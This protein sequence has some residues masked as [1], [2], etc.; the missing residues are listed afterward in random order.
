M[1]AINSNS[2]RT[3]QGPLT[4]WTPELVAN[5]P[6]PFMAYTRYAQQVL[7]I[8]YASTK[9]MVVLRQRVDDVFDR[10]PQATWYSLCRIVNWCKTKRIRKPR[11][12][13]LVDLVPE[14]WAARVLPELDEPVRDENIERRIADALVVETDPSWRRRLIGAM[15][16]SSR[17]RVLNDWMLSRG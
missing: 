7:G 8:P 1:P 13:M 2:H 15:G 10:C 14:A 11:V 16:N 4:V 3:G 9:D 17:N 5:A 6:D 12:Y